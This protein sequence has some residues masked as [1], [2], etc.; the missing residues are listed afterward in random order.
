ME[1]KSGWIRV[2]IMWKKNGGCIRGHCNVQIKNVDGYG[3]VL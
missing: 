3:R 2:D 1:F